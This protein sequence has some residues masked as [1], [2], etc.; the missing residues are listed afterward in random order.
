MAIEK[1]SIDRKY[2]ISAYTFD[3]YKSGEWLGEFVTV[4]DI[5]Y[6]K[7]PSG[8]LTKYEIGNDVQDIVRLVNIT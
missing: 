2:F 5:L 3:L 6:R 1:Y 8:I 4:D 7:D